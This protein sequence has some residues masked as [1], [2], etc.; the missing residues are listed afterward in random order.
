MTGAAPQEAFFVRCDETNNP[1][2]LRAQGQLLVEI[3]IAPTVPFEFIVLRI[4]REAN[5]F[6]LIGDEPMSRA[7]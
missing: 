3:A 2:K 6:S 7:A 5:S 1:P 4:G